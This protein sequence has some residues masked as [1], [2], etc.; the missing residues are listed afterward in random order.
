MG[1]LGDSALGSGRSLPGDEVHLARGFTHRQWATY[2]LS[3]SIS[4]VASLAE[5]PR[6]A[7]LESGFGEVGLFAEYVDSPCCSSVEWKHLTFADSAALR[8]LTLTG[9]QP[10][11]HD[12]NSLQL[13]PGNK[14]LA[15][16][17][18]IYS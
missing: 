1:T 17:L 11:L 16:L 9:A 10:K 13:L 18:D 14:Q 12:K 3:V 4:F 7:A 15:F 5:T 6:R 8:T 2:P